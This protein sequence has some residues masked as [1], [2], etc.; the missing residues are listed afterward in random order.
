VIFEE[1]DRRPFDAP[2]RAQHHTTLAA[3]GLPTGEQPVKDRPRGLEAAMSSRPLGY[4]LRWVSK[5]EM[6]RRRASRAEGSW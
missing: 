2:G 4:D 6:M 1:T 5:N 3:D